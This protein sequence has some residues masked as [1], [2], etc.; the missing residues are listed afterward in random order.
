MYAIAPDFI[1]VRM[2]EQSTQFPN[3]F[4]HKLA[5]VCNYIGW[6]SLC[7]PPQPHY[8]HTLNSLGGDNHRR[9]RIKLLGIFTFQI[10]RVCARQRQLP[11]MSHRE[12]WNYFHIANTH[13]QRHTQ[14]VFKLMQVHHFMAFT[15]RSHSQILIRSFESNVLNSASIKL[16]DKLKQT[17]NTN[18]RTCT[19]G[20]NEHCCHIQLLSAWYFSIKV[21]PLYI[22][23]MIV[24]KITPILR[25]PN[26]HI[27]SCTLD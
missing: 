11:S 17:K 3:L 6:N 9:Q 14:I 16:H 2:R 8:Y 1:W 18:V 10:N 25:I 7:W 12:I 15:L 24:H 4:A 26:M 22:F 13:T 5:I 23:A 21:H 19:T 20:S 27:H